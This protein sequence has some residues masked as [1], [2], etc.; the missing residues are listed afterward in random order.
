MHILCIKLEIGQGVASTIYKTPFTSCYLYS[1]YN[2]NIIH[3]DH[4]YPKD[5]NLHI[6]Q[7]TMSNSSTK[8]IISYVTTVMCT[9]QFTKSKCIHVNQNID[10]WLLQQPQY[11]CLN[12]IIERRSWM[13]RYIQTHMS[14]QQ[15][16]LR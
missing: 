11:V 6:T 15:Q 9:L 5:C 12:H 2:Y 3:K 1:G 10:I 16:P 4:I 13:V 7:L 14:K 8:I